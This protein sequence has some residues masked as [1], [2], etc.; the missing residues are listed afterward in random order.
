MATVGTALATA[1][2]DIA[3]AAMGTIQA[4][5]PVVVPIL[6]AVVLI[7][8]GIRVFKKVAGR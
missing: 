5:L 8:I 4:V 7:G 6:G 2:G 3:D 1:F